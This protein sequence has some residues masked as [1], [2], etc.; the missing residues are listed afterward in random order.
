MKRS[1][2]TKSNAISGSSHD[3]PLAVLLDVHSGE[4]QEAKTCKVE[5]KEKKG[6]RKRELRNHEKVRFH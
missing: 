6:K 4:D 5:K 2:H 1:L 3:S